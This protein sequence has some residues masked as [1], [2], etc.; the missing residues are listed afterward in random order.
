MWGGQRRNTA[1]YL[2]RARIHDHHSPEDDILCRL[3][4]SGEVPGESAGFGVGIER[5]CQVYL[6]LPDVLSFM[7]CPEFVRERP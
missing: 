3:I 7:A 4:D 1:G 5:L 6:G 2:A